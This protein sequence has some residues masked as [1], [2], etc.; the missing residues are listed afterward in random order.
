IPRHRWARKPAA[1]RESR[2][3]HRVSGDGRGNQADLALHLHVHQA[4]GMASVADDGEDDRI[5]ATITGAD[6]DPL[7]IK[8]RD[9]DGDEVLPGEQR[10]L[11]VKLA[12][13]QRTLCESVKLILDGK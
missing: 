1:C 12:D 2:S 13:D 11:Q 4:I 6:L 7:L 5:D 10:I 3:C 8:L 9:A